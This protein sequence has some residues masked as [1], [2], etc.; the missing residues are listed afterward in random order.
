M[1]SAQR[2]LVEIADQT[3]PSECKAS[4]APTLEE[5]LSGLRTA[6]RNGESLFVD[7]RR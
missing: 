5:F 3:V 2:R 6:W 7:V 4:P 1:R